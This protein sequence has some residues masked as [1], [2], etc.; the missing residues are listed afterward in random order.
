MIKISSLINILKKNNSNFFTG[1]PDSVLKE[2][3]IY[4][5]KKNKKNHVIATNEGSAV[6]I[7]IGHYLSTNKIPSVYMQNS[8]LSNALNPLISIAHPKVYSIPLVLIIGWRGSPRVND[9]PQHNVKGK[10]TEKLLKLLNIKYTII[11]S[12]N[13]LKKFNKQIKEAK[14]NK[15][16]VACLIEQGTLKKNN[17]KNTKKD[18]YKVDKENFFKTLLEILDNKSKIISSTGYNSREIIH[19][20]NKYQL[21]KSKDFYMVGGMGHTSSVALGY[22]L[23]TNKKTICIDGDG[24]FLMHLGS[25]KT[26]GNF[27]NKN[28]KYILLNNNTHDSVGGQSTYVKNIDL[29]KLSKSLG[30]KKFYS[31]KDNQNLRKNL[32]K[33]LSG[34]SLNFLEVKVTNSK[35]K[36]LPRPKNLINIKNQFMK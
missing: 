13:D 11:R 16:I 9:E 21:K 18:F 12:N 24:S 29:E 5:Q 32:K 14:K 31:I 6:S 8:G 4:L 36:N 1:V 20:R 25:I 35:I 7:A 15:T 10:I 3:S 19:I 30:F 17:K 27:A 34:N 33:F 23:S 22:S 2:L 28:F 26:A